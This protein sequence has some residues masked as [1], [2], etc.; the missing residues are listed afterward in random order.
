MR[1]ACFSSQLATNTL[2]LIK[3][4]KHA[5]LKSV[6]YP[7]RPDRSV[8][9]QG[10][11]S[12]LPRFSGAQAAEG[13]VETKTV[14]TFYL[15]PNPWGGSSTAGLS[16]RFLRDG[17]GKKGKQTG[18]LAQ[19]PNA[20]QKTPSTTLSCGVAGIKRW[21]TKS[22]LTF[23]FPSWTQSQWIKVWIECIK[24]KEKRI[25]S[26]DFWQ[27]F[28]ME[29]GRQCLQS[30]FPV[31]DHSDEVLFQS[32]CIHQRWIKRSEGWGVVP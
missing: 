3:I 26:R 19:S 27:W 9:E 31:M 20:W 25:T 7:I 15:M 22:D 29:I 4:F 6:A 10:P 5:D 18:A 24:E 1:L 28:P 16:G 21:K 2:L 11:L 23:L 32:I 30:G 14:V 17:D 12:V 13:Q 8:F